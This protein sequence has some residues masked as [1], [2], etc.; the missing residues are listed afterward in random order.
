MRRRRGHHYF[1][2]HQPGPPKISKNYFV[3]FGT[4]YIQSNM[5]EIEQL[6]ISNSDTE[7]SVSYDAENDQ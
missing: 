3:Y 6:T 5:Q 7:L 2:L 1:L 4:R